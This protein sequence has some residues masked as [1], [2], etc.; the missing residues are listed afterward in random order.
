MKSK[1]IN[2]FLLILVLFVISSNASAQI[3]HGYSMAIAN[4]LSDHNFIITD[5]G[6]IDDGE[7]IY[8]VYMKTSDFYDEDLTRMTITTALMLYSDVKR[9]TPWEGS[10]GSSESTYRIND[11]E[12]EIHISD[13]GTDY[14]GM[15]RGCSVSIYESINPNWVKKSSSSKR[16]NSS[17]KKRTSKRKK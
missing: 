17:H 9:V 8:C 4:E 2:N 3:I 6:F 7:S 14:D 5:R 10:Y 15:P 13:L 12:I 16:K 1:L 11:T